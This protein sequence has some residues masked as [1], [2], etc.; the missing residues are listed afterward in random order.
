MILKTHFSASGAYNLKTNSMTP[1]FH[2][3]ITFGIGKGNCIIILKKFY[4]AEFLQMQKRSM[5]K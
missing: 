1:I 3:M 5:C 2:H 4:E